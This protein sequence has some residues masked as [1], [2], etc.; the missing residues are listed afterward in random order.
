MDRRNFLT[1]AAVSPLA[2]PLNSWGSLGFMLPHVTNLNE[3][4]EA[5]HD[6]FIYL[7]ERYNGT[8]G[9]PMGITDNGTPY[10][11][12]CVGGPKGEGEPQKVRTGDYN[13][14]LSLWYESLNKDAR[15]SGKSIVWRTY[16]EVYKDLDIYTITIQSRVAF[17]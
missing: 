12:Y 4:R 15:N 8:M 13:K 1:A 11:T 6:C 9:R 14:A 10:L 3:L 2:F 16:P 7:N 17:E 5:V